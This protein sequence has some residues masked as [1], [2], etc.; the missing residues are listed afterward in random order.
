MPTVIV[1]IQER[2]LRRYEERCE[3]PEVAFQ[4]RHVQLSIPLRIQGRL[5][6]V[7]ARGERAFG[8]W[9]SFD[10][11]DGP[12]VPKLSDELAPSHALQAAARSM[13]RTFAKLCLCGRLPEDCD[14]CPACLGKGLLA[15]GEGTQPCAH[16]AGLGYVIDEL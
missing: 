8:G 9:V 14:C 11:P 15:A 3:I 6:E 5:A 16:C 13:V 2:V 10:V 4:G 7:N 12:E 1:R